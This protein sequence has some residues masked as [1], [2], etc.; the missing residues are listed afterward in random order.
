MV[1]ALLF[2]GLPFHYRQNTMKHF[3]PTSDGDEDGDTM[4]FLSMGFVSFETLLGCV[5]FMGAKKSLLFG[6]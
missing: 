4:A 2:Y 5:V 6:E 3:F 1:P